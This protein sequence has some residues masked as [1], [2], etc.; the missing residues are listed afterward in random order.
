MPLRR[1]RLKTDATGRAHAG[2][3][4]RM[5]MYVNERPQLISE[6]IA[7]ALLPQKLDVSEMVWVSPLKHKQYC[8]YQDEEF[9]EVAGAGHFAARLKTFW[10]RG[11]PCWDALAR[12]TSGGCVLVEAKS[13]VLEV[14]GNGCGARG[15][16]RELIES[17]LNRTKRWLG[18]EERTDWL[19][20]LYQ[21]ANRI[22]HLYF[23]RELCGIN[24]FLANVFFL[25]DPHS[26]FATTQEQWESGIGTAYEQLGI[27]KSIPFSGTVFLEA[28]CP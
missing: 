17:S 5:Q 19:G 10:P 21:S 8:E 24:A 23:L 6:A 14:Y 13:H 9:L 26:K 1:D 4:L 2:S 25:N 20:P 3:Q 27:R 11:G 28:R 16:P 12:L 7:K 15:K 18:V 22:A